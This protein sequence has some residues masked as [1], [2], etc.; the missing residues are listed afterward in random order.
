MHA[1]PQT[2]DMDQLILL[3]TCLLRICS[4]SLHTWGDCN[5]LPMILKG[6]SLRWKDLYQFPSQH[7]IL[8]GAIILK[9]AICIFVTF[10]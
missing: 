10:V 6:I 5:L 2:N 3:N 8:R 4:R 9:N 1:M 7:L